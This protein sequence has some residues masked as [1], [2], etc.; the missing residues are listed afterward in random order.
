MF[1]HTRFWNPW[2]EF[3]QLRDEMHR[4]FFAGEPVGLRG[5]RQYPALNIW[6]GEDG[7]VVTAELPG[8]KPDELDIT[9]DDSTLTI[10][11]EP[12]DADDVSED[13]DESPTFHR[14]ERFPAGFTRVV[15]L[16]FAVDR[17]SAEA[18][19]EHGVLTLK[20]SRPEQE[21]PRRIAVTAA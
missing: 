1:N 18:T 6:Q 20:L 2:P 19:Y 15:N 7:F 12:A 10:R 17:D 5:G 14:R 9:I 11:R 21:K 8:V 13:A 4:L 3:D 16:P